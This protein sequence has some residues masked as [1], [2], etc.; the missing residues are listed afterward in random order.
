M[1]NPRAI[2]QVLQGA[3]ATTPAKLPAVPRCT[4]ADKGTADAVNA[5]KERSE[6]REGARGNPFEKTALLRDLD[7]LGLTRTRQAPCRPE[8]LAGIVGQT[9]DGEFVLISLEDLARAVGDKISQ[10]IGN[11]FA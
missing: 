3:V 1:S 2:N 10:S 5:L 4:N 6:V 7:D 8:D 9:K 11:N